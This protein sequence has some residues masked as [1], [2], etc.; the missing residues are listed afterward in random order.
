MA[1]SIEATLEDVRTHHALTQ[2][3]GLIDLD[4]VNQEWDEVEETLLLYCIPRW[5]VDVCP[6]CG[7]L[8]TRIHD[9]PEQRHIHDA[10]LRGN[11]TLLVFDV[12]RLKCDHCQHVFTLRFRDIVTDCTYTKRL[13]ME[14]GMPKRKQ[15]VQTLSELYRIGYK[16]VESILLKASDAKIARRQEDPVV[17]RQLGIDEL[18]NRKGQGNYVLVLTD[19]ERRIV[20]DILPDRQKATLIQ[21]LKKPTAGID[22]SQLETAATDLWSHYRDAVVA[23]FDDKVKIVADRFH[24]MQN[25][26]EAIHKARRQAQKQAATEEERKQLK[27]LRY[28]LLKKDAKLTDKEKQRLQGLKSVHPQLY[29]LTRLRQRLYEWYEAEYSIKEAT[30]ELNQWLEDAK[31]LACKPLNIFCQT[32]QNWQT[33]IVNFFLTA[34]PAVSLKE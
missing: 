3:M 13:S 34:S 20:L 19:L 26:H 31:V 15:D 33:E 16:T 10:P 28:L 29:G 22:L 32:L 18:S 21:W 6:E 1:K 30:Q 23:V 4:V 25:L 7:V 12:H 8:A 24:V 2:A 14:I 9:Y 5:G 17:V 27:G 11:K